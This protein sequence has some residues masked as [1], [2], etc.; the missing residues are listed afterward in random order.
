MIPSRK[1]HPRRASERFE[2]GLLATVLVK[3][4]ALLREGMSVRAQ[5]ITGAWRGGE[6]PADRQPG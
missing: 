4:V 1:T 2:K 3:T 5:A 6:R